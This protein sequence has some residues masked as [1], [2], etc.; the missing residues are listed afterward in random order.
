MSTSFQKFEL[1]GEVEENKNLPL[2]QTW[3]AS[4]MCFIPAVKWNS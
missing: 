4:H 1:Q 2:T 3:L